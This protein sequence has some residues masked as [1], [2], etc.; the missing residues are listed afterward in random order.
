M[1]VDFTDDIADAGLGGGCS[2]LLN[3]GGGL[4]ACH[5]EAKA[6]NISKEKVSILLH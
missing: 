1:T 2:E 4:G 5:L 3:G 6:M